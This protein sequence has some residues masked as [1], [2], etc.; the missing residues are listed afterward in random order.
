MVSG[1]G[2]KVVVANPPWPGK[3]Y[4]ARSN[5]RWPHRR[6]DK[7]L[8]YPIYLA[9][10]VALLKRSSF[11]AK[12]VDAVF[13]EWDIG[14]FVREMQSMKPGAVLLEVSTP[15]IDCDLETAKRLKEILPG[16]MLVFCGPHATYFSEE[17]IREHAFV[18][19]VIRGE[20]EFAFKEIC[21]ALREKRSFSGIKGITY[22]DNAGGVKRAEDRPLLEDLDKLPW[23]DRE[24]FPIGRYQQAFYCGRKTALMVSSRG[25]PFQCTYCLWPSTLTHRRYRIRDQKKVVDEIKFLIKKEGIDE[26]FFDDDEFIINKKKVLD[27]CREMIRR[28]IRIKWHCMG[29]VDIVDGELLGMMKEAGCY[30]IF[31]GFESG[32]EKILKSLKKGITKAQI[33]RAVGL[34]KKAGIVCG[35]SFILGTPEESWETLK[36]TTG[37]AKSLGSDWVQF[38]L[39]SPFP[40]TP[41]YEEAKR[42]GLLEASSWSDFDGS[43]GPIVRTKYLSRKDLEGVQRKAYLS[44]YTAPAVIWANLRS[45]RS[46]RQAKR[47]ARGMRSVISRLLYYD[48]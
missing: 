10:A 30:Q 45:V 13:N 26:V 39:C 27:F 19:A 8:P 46:F 35:G 34:T 28:G 2:M 36:E 20:F 5:V 24:D 11:D 37:F 48:K 18:D 4:G 43:K 1:D 42:S 14:R 23:P 22:R 40:G 21:E 32:S 12:G 44:Y 15:S 31:Y 29:R 3:G 16:T 33:R 9:Y 17:I 7:K 41:M 38:A 25:C 47:I 6:G